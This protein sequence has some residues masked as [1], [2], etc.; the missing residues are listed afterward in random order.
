LAALGRYTI[1]RKLATG[2]MAEV[3]LAKVAGPGGFEKHV[4]LKSI[5][6]QLADNEVYVRMFL[7]EARLAAQL[8]HPNIVHVF[9]FGQV[10][11]TYF[12]TMEYVEGA[13]LRQLTR[14]ASRPENTALV[15]TLAARIIAEACHGLSYAHQFT[16]PGGSEVRRLVHR[17]V[18]PENIMVARNGAVKVLDFGVAKNVTDDSRSV[19]DGVLKGKLSFMPPE[20]LRGQELDNRTDI[21]ALGVVL[22]HVLSGR[23]PY[24]QPSDVALVQAVLEEPP[25]PLLKYRPDLRDP[26][27]ELVTRAMAKSPDHRFQSCEAMADALEAYIASEGQPQGSAQLARLIQAFLASEKL[28]VATRQASSR[29][30]SRS[31]SPPGTS[32]SRRVLVQGDEPPPALPPGGVRSS[33]A[34]P[35]LPLDDEPLDLPP[36]PATDPAGSTIPGGDPPPSAPV[37]PALPA[38][39]SAP[40]DAPLAPP[41][42]RVESQASSAAQVPVAVQ[43]QTSTAPPKQHAVGPATPSKRPP[44]PPGEGPIPAAP[45]QPLALQRMAPSR[46]PIDDQTPLALPRPLHLLRSTPPAPPDEDKTPLALLRPPRVRRSKPR[47]AP[48]ALGVEAQTGAALPTPSAP[49]AAAEATAGVRAAPVERRWVKRPSAVEAIRQTLRDTHRADRSI[50]LLRKLPAVIAHLCEGAT[51]ASP[52]LRE[53]LGGAIDAAVLCEDHS[54]VANLLSRAEQHRGGAGCFA[55]LVD[56]EL[57]SPLRLAWL[58]ERLRSGMPADL[59]GL[60]AWLSAL[61]ASG[62]SLLVSAIEV[63]DRWSEQELFAEALAGSDPKLILSRLDAPLPQTAAAFSFALERSGSDERAAVFAR[64][65]RE[66]PVEVVVEVLAGRAQARGERAVELLEASLDDPRAEVRARALALLGQLGAER[67]FEVLKT[68][69]LAPSFGTLSPLEAEQS[70]AALLDAGGEAGL[71]VAAKLLSPKPAGPASAHDDQQRLVV[72]EALRRRNTEGAG[73]LLERTVVDGRHSAAVLAKA[74]GAL[75]TPRA[76]NLE[77]DNR[78]HVLA[79]VSLDLALLARAATTIDLRSNLLEGALERLREGVRQ[80]GEQGQWLTVEATESGPR[81]GGELVGFGAFEAAAPL[82]EQ[83]LRMRGLKKLSVA[84][85]VSVAELRSLLL[86]A[87]DPDGRHEPLKNVTAFDVADQPLV[88][89]PEG[90]AAANAGERALEL[91]QRVVTWLWGPRDGVSSLLDIDAELDEWVELMAEKEVPHLGVARWDAGT[92]RGRCERVANIAATAMAFA[93]DLGLSRGCLRE[94]A[95]L[96]LLLGLSDPLRATSQSIQRLNRLGAAVGVAAFEA[97]PTHE[98]LA[99]SVSLITSVH[100]LA[101]A[102]EEGVGQEGLTPAD[103]AAQMSAEP[104]PSFGR[105]LLDLFRQWALAQG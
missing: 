90:A 86:R 82:W 21:Y 36:E 33:L 4:V 61:S 3:Y 62:G 26:L 71:A 64:L 58:V 105:E 40:V 67:G 39:R 63:G 92:E 10:D 43:V 60:R 19:V 27:L 12:L 56:E 83:A 81:V 35:K 98:R 1:L 29:T 57:Q 20:Q 54:A 45:L 73:A 17:D 25:T 76:P 103:A 38:S 89:R 13:T 31:E 15:P 91:Y 101:Q 41:S 5:L 65:E 51:D 52:E 24:E 44:V 7:E 96:S 23:M 88:P 102:F 8:D 100:A 37:T 68:R 104:E 30:G 48:P 53:V 74:R 93:R 2:G 9:D 80:V 72:I 87:F 84:A 28:P 78:A 11:G 42:R 77:L 66:S 32:A 85:Q 94:L 69:V 95:E 34:T 6:P 59:A 97:D 55:R 47:A 70:W 16:P 46:P 79:R 22:F 18:S 75:V 49:P 99:G 14:W 50:Y